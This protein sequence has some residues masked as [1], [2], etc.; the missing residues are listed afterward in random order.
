MKNLISSNQRVIQTYQYTYD[1]KENRVLT[2][3]LNFL[4]FFFF[5]NLIENQLQKWQEVA[6]LF[7]L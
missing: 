7:F 1:F 2:E 6:I 5:S 3:T 4:S